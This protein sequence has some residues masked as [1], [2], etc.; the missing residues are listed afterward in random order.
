MSFSWGVIVM[1]HSLWNCLIIA[2]V[3]YLYGSI[4]FGYL[5]TRLFAHK[6]V[7]EHGTGTIGVANTFTV[8]GKRAGYLT[9]LGEASKG[10]LPVFIVRALFHSVEPVLI[11]VFFALLGT[12]FPIFLPGKYTKGRTLIGWASL[13]LS[14]Y[15]TITVG[16]IW[17]T[18]AILFK[19]AR[20]SFYVSSLSYPFFLYLFENHV[21]YL[22]FGLC[23]I[24]VFFIRSGS[25]N[26]DF[27][28]NHI[29]E[30]WQEKF[31]ASKSSNQRPFP[32]QSGVRQQGL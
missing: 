18:T 17:T 6:K 14:F 28:K 13:F 1:N 31:D 27:N 29:F 11:G 21:A 19:K 22:V 8:G 9:V 32:C 12:S 25:H 24:T 23:V 30:K 16:L 5:F 4:P 2:I 7:Y 15:T 10:L 3:A 26:D 20:V